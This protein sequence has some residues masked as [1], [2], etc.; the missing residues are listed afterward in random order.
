[1][2]D[3]ADVLAIDDLVVTFT[4]RQTAIGLDKV[5]FG[6]GKEEILGI[7]GETGSGKSLTLLAI[8]GLLPQSARISAGSIRYGARELT[9]LGSASYRDLRG[10]EISIV[11]QNA[12][13]ALNPLARIGD[14]IM[15]VYRRKI[16]LDGGALQLRM[17]DVLSKVGFRDI[18]RVLSA[19]PHQISGGMAQRILIAIALGPSP[20]LVLFDEPTSGLDTTVGVKV[21]DPIQRTV[22]EA[23]ASAIVVTHDLGIV[24]RFCDRVVVMASGRIVD[25]APVEEFFNT[26]DNPHRRKLV[27]AHSW[28]TLAARGDVDTPDGAEG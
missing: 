4:A 15:E 23:K 17:R 18:D 20:K 12:K 7:V 9:S 11:V 3:S 2:R 21:M 14:Q 28:A 25:T 1:M 24:A 5:S 22:R 16:A 13:A 6:V 8:M 27:E 10:R 19:Y 26:G